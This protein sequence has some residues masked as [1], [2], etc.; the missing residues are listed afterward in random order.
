MIVFLERNVIPYD[1]QTTRH[2]Q[3]DNCGAAARSQQ[4]IFSA[5]V[6]GRDALTLK[7]GLE[8][9]RDRP[10]QPPITHDHPFDAVSQQSRGYP[11]SGGFDFW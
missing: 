2:A 10:T 1:S 7:I 9:C 5:P 3:V 4:Q 6:Y 8:A 11:L